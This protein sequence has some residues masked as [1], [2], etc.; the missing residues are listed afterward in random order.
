MDLYKFSV[1]DM[2][3]AAQKYN[4]EPNGFNIYEQDVVQA[5]RR[6]IQNSLPCLEA[7]CA[8]VNAA[9]SLMATA[10]RVKTKKAA[11]FS[12]SLKHRLEKSI[13]RYISN[14]AT[15]LAAYMIN[16]KVWPKEINYVPTYNGFIAIRN[17]YRFPE[18]VYTQDSDVM[19]HLGR[20]REQVPSDPPTHFYQQVL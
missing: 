12:Y 11:T 5:W 18:Y 1:A 10:E 14:G 17:L 15:L 20:M 3:D 13:D 9:A 8:Q 19:F 16:L 2:L 4:I 6:S 7:C